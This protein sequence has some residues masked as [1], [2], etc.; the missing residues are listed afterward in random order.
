MGIFKDFGVEPVLLLAQAINFLILLF[1][2]KKI[3]Y[4]PILKVL[5]DRKKRIE[6]SLLQAEQIKAEL[7]KAEQSRREIIK[8]ASERSNLILEESKQGAGKLITE[9]RQF[10]KKEA[11]IILHRTEEALAAEREKMRKE[12]EKEVVSLV[13]TVSAKVLGK[14]LTQDLNKKITNETIKELK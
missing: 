8:E 5:E 14:V 1:V 6:E 10:A 12:L 2:L 11:E 3:L 9:A 4:K 13:V 7:E